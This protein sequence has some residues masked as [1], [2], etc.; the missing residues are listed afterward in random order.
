MPKSRV[1]VVEDHFWSVACHATMVLQRN[2]T[3]S[4]IN[5]CHFNQN[6]QL[7]K[8]LQRIK[9]SVAIKFYKLS[10]MNRNKYMMQI[11]INCKDLFLPPHPP[12]VHIN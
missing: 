2:Y 12:T 6:H 4:Y 7:K 3:Y 10:Y 5:H 9:G 8:K 1:K 11:H